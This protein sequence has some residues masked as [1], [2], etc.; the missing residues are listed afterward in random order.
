MCLLFLL[1]SKHVSLVVVLGDKAR[2]NI[3][4]EFIWRLCRVYIRDL[5]LGLLACYEVNRCRFYSRKFVWKT[6][7]VNYFSPAVF[8]HLEINMHHFAHSAFFY[9]SRSLFVFA[10][11]H[12]S[13]LSSLHPHRCC[14]RSNT[15]KCL[16]CEIGGLDS[17]AFKEILYMMLHNREQMSLRHHSACC[18]KAISNKKK[19]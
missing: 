3:Y 2:S 5:R 17:K 19:S 9:W 18:S 6:L 14:D 7:V 1:V 8:C 15:Y 11:G 10:K 12:D 16:L 13:M 4:S